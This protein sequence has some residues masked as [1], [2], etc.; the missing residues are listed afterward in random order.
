MPETISILGAF[1]ALIAKLP[2]WIVR[3][4][5]PAHRLA[6]L[7]Y[8]DIYPRNDSTWMN[9]GSAP[10][11][12]IALQVINLSPFPCEVEQG[13]LN[14]QCGGVTIK[15]NLLQRMK[16][17]PAEVACIYLTESLSDGQA[18]TMRANWGSSATSLAGTV[19]VASSVNR[20]TKHVQ[21][22]SGI[23]VHAANLSSERIDA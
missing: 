17:A 23:H 3:R 14:L 8:I 21:A 13:Q 19:E 2:A 15:L 6:D 4:C 10:E 22:L 7:L 16:L 12:R 5:Y 9:F 18:K 1:R 11:V 20:F